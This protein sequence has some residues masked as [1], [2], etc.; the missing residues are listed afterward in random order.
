MGRIEAS[1]LASRL[2]RGS[3]WSFAGS[4]MARGLG[5]IAA[6]VAARIL[7][8]ASYGELGII[9][10]TVGMFGTLAGFGMGA[11]ATKYVAELRSTD[12]ERAGRIIGLSSLV[13][14]VTGLGLAFLLL[15]LSP[16]LCS[17]TLAAPHLTTYMQIGSLLLL[18]SGVNGAQN[19]VLSGFEAFKAIARVNSI[20]G[21]LN[22]PLVVG[23]AYMFGLSGLVW[24]MILAQ[25]IGCFLNYSALRCEAIRYQIA[26]SYS[27]CAAELSILWR[28]AVPAVLGGLLVGP[29]N[30]ACA[31]MLVHKPGGYAQMGALNAA[32]QW[33][34]ALMWLPYMLGAVVMPMLAER[35]GVNDGARSAKLLIASIKINAAVTLPLILVG[36]VCS[37]YIMSGY[38]KDFAREWPT[39]VATLITA[40]LFAIEIPVGHVIAA[41]GRMWLGFCMNFIYAMAVVTASWLLLGWGSLGL[42]SARLLAYAV[43]AVWTF[44]YATKVIRTSMGRRNRDRSLRAHWATKVATEKI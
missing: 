10:S 1:P 24:G 38:G 11:T 9:Q 31:A 36:S 23:G 16:W 4:V 43:H 17:K 34:N 33:F 35:L 3:F 5:L 13:S 29:A 7:G 21:A 39:L 40:G 8:K 25:A 32:N 2:A 30:W 14:W 22:F 37:P 44:S 27:S 18:L 15:M 41:S 26:I 28:F 42:A 12:P 6:M 19:G 20:V